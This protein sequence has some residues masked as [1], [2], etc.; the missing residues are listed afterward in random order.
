MYIRCNFLVLYELSVVLHDRVTN[1]SFKFYSFSFIFFKTFVCTS[2]KKQLHNLKKI[3]TSLFKTTK[4]EHS[5]RKI[6]CNYRQINNKRFS[7]D[8]LHEIDGSIWGDLETDLAKKSPKSEAPYFLQKK[9]GP[10]I[11]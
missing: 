11:F 1:K 6:D 8:F 5:L 10:R 3:L 4:Y 2:L 9:K 7:L